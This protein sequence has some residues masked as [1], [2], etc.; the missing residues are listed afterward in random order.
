MSKNRQTPRDDARSPNSPEIHLPEVIYIDEITQSSHAAQRFLPTVFTNPTQAR[1]SNKST[2]SARVPLASIPV[3]EY[4]RSILL[5]VLAETESLLRLGSALTRGV[6]WELVQVRDQG[7]AYKPAKWNG[8]PLDYA[9]RQAYSRAVLRLEGFG[10]LR[11][12]TEP[13]RDRVTQVQLTAVGL[14][15]ALRLAGRHADR[16]AI[17]EGLRL[18]NWG[19]ELAPLI[20]VKPPQNK[21][22]VSVETRRP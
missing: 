12:I 8:T 17:A 10:V 22:G 18:T 7:I 2:R 3:N 19:R 14:R 16:S 4:A 13:H 11:R 21:Q 5:S 15:L 20:R 1:S 9:Q 6:T